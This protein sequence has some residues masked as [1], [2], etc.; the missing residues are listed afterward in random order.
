MY[1]TIAITVV[2][3]VC[4]VGCSDN[5]GAG[6]PTAPVSGV[7][8][9]NGEPVQYA[10]VIFFPQKVDGGRTA[11]AVT[12]AEVR[13]SNA[14]GVAVGSHFVT[15]TEGWPPGQEIPEDEEG[16]EIEPP[17]GPWDN[18]YRDSTDPPLKVEIVAGQDNKFDFDISE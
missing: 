17:R 3:S 15:V 7:L 8:I 6:P 5:S 18:K 14:D 2:F 4:G 11:L 12:D 1:R 13:F 10:N 16:M 9:Y